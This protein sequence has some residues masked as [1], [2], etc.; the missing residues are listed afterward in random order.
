MEGLTYSPAK[1]RRPKWQHSGGQRVRSS[2]GAW[3]RREWEW[4]VLWA[5]DAASECHKRTPSL[6]GLYHDRLWTMGWSVLK[7]LACRS[8][9]Y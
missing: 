9:S 3:F 6:F 1:D 2:W 4:Y 8:H 5:W 7:L